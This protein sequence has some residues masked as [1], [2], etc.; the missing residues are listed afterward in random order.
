MSSGTLVAIALSV[1]IV[2]AGVVAA[3]IFEARLPDPAARA[4][5][6]AEPRPS[7]DQRAIPGPVEAQ[8]AGQYTP[9]AS[10]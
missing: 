5:G 4:S 10:G 8:S 6:A 2:M 3:I 1:L 9:L 7:G